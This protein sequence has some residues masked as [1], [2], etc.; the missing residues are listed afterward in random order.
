MDCVIILKLFLRDFV[1]LMEQN[2]TVAEIIIF[3]ILFFYF[4]NFVLQL[5]PRK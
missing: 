5:R 1:H 3:N 4:S 2:K